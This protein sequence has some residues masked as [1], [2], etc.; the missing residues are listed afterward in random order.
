[1]SYESLVRIESE[2]RGWKIKR[3]DREIG[4][5]GV[6]CFI[7]PRIAGRCE[8]WVGVEPETDRLHA[9]HEW[10]RGALHAAIIR[11]LSEGDLSDRS[12]AKLT[13]GVIGSTPSSCTLSIKLKKRDYAD[14][15]EAL[16]T[17][18][19]VVYSMFLGQRRH[20]SESNARP[21]KFDVLGDQ[22]PEAVEWR[23]LVASDHVA[24]VGLG[25]VGA[26][27]ADFVAKSDVREVHGWDHDC[28]EP[29]NILRMP[30]APDPGEWIGKPKA[31]WFQDT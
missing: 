14:A 1:M 9:S 2:R 31:K 23:D 28:I 29:K 26:W 3:R 19:K 30:G 13:K 16:N 4:A 12:G 5:V 11:G 20:G 8:I 15:W 7:A 6:P 25:G 24:V 22:V 21:Y 10:Q 17:Y 27:I 18:V